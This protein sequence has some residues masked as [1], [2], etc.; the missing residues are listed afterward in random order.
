MIAVGILILT[1]R[2]TMLNT[3]L[4]KV[5]FFRRKVL[6]RGETARRKLLDKGK[7]GLL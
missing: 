2:L 1:G 6:I 4:N 5:S 7:G 3:W